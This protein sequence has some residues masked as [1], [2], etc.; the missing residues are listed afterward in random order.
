M[1][2]LIVALLAAL[3][4]V[5]PVNHAA[6]IPQFDS[7]R[8]AVATIQ[9]QRIARDHWQQAAA[10]AEAQRIQRDADEEHEALV[11][12]LEA[13]QA[14]AERAAVTLA[15]QREADRTA[16][17]AAQRVVQQAQTA[18]PILT[19]TAQPLRVAPQ[20]VPTY[21]APSSS[22]VYLG[23]ALRAALAQ[24]SWPSGLWAAV[25]RVVRCESGGKT[26][27]VSPTGYVGLMQ[28]APWYHG[29]PPSD[30]VGQLE[31]AWGVYLQQG[32]GAWECA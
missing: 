6:P 28:I 22:G 1:L 18:A 20:P 32:W 24:T 23:D 13:Q 7:L 8:Y 14:A 9:S 4:L 2:M 29:Y 27:A 12:T 30:A 21:V 3:G 31:Q 10:F 25:E 26:T 11:A 15:A 17:I 5:N 16:A 19:P